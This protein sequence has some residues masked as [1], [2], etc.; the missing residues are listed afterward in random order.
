MVAAG[1][2]SPTETG[3]TVTMKNAS[4]RI[5]EGTTVVMTALS[6]PGLLSAFQGIPDTQL[7][8]P[9][10]V[11]VALLMGRVGTDP[12]AY[13]RVAAS[14]FH[15]LIVERDDSESVEFQRLE[16]ILCALL[17]YDGRTFLAFL[18]LARLAGEHPAYAGI[19][20]RSLGL[21]AGY[22]RKRRPLPLPATELDSAL[23]VLE[24]NDG[25]RQLASDCRRLLRRQYK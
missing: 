25:L 12:A 5:G 23:L 8:R 10:P 3:A 17:D 21:V 13:T 24:E 20:V 4:S 14:A 6:W 19:G 22:L 7:V 9:Y 2:H 11:S 18:Q 1:P 16:K 15:N